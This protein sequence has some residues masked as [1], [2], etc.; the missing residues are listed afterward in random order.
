MKEAED[1]FLKVKKD[2][3]RF[4][5]KEKIINRSKITKIKNL[6]KN[7]I[8][9]SFWIEK[10]YKEKG[11][12]LFLGLSGGQGAGKTTMTGILKIILNKFFKRNVCVT[13]IDHFYKTLDERNV[14]SKQIHPLFKTRGVPGT[15][16]IML[17]KKFFNKI[18][19]N[20]FK[21]FKIPKFDKSIDDR[22]KNKYWSKISK[23]PEIVILEGWCV[24]AKPQSNSLIKKPINILERKEDRRL[25]WRK[26]VNEKLKNEYK[27]VFSMIDHL[28]F[29]KVPSFDMVFQWRLLQE[30]KLKKISYLNKKI[31]NYNQ[32]KRFI[33]FYQRITLQMI[34]DLSKSASIIIFLKKNHEIKKVLYKKK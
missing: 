6:K 20:K 28:I 29:L 1:C 13:S 34:K 22:I 10:K 25:I 4:L 7:Y 26:Y 24:G 16:D 31:M 8:P 19:K 12:T 5:K 9:I 33:M 23:K 18:K 17:V 3:L 14:M 21:E 30:A 11:K 27:K 15:H 32:I 2:Y